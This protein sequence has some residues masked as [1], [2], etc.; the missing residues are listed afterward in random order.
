MSTNEED[1]EFAL[2]VLSPS[3]EFNPRFFNMQPPVDGRN[4]SDPRYF[5]YTSVDTF[6]TELTYWNFTSR[7][8]LIAHRDGTTTSLRPSDPLQVAG[9]NFYPDKID[10][11]LDG[12]GDWTESRQ[13]IRWKNAEIRPGI[14][15]VQSKILDKAAREFGQTGQHSALS[16][17]KLEN[18][19][20]QYGN[21]IDEILESNYPNADRVNGE[22][23]KGPFVYSGKIGIAGQPMYHNPHN[24]AIPP[25]YID[26]STVV[27]FIDEETLTAIRDDHVYLSVLDISIGYL[28]NKSRIVHPYQQEEEQ[29]Q[30]ILKHQ[31][32]LKYKGDG[33]SIEV[34]DNLQRKEYETLYFRLGYK[35]ISVNSKV[36]PTKEDGIYYCIFSANN[37]V[38]YHHY[39]LTSVYIPKGGSESVAYWSCSD[40]LVSGDAVSLY[41]DAS[42]Q[43]EEY[44]KRAKADIEVQYREYSHEIDAQYRRHSNRNAIYG[45]QLKLDAEL[46]MNAIREKHAVT[47]NQLESD[48]KIMTESIKLYREQNKQLDQGVNDAFDTVLKALKLII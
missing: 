37:I 21:P 16:I 19:D 40:A 18:G 39:P 28:I 34:I 15:I 12:K 43:I 27:Y 31:G 4:I 42:N 44:I 11:R 14:Y 26:K 29:K 38:E 45:A 48:M 23:Y 10:I 41:D 17:N 3:S 13:D 7:D 5:G 35:I 47:M 46:R 9:L 36:D 20:V 2:T 25:R 6:K 22:L 24:P 32:E 1:D 30:K 8:V 33:I